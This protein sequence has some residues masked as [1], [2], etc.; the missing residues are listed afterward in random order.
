MPG[1]SPKMVGPIVHNQPGLPDALTL[2]GF[3][4]F[5]KV[6]IFE[7]DAKGNLTPTFF[8]RQKFGYACQPGQAPRHKYGQTKDEHL[9]YIKDKG[10]DIKNVNVN[11][12]LYSVVVT[13]EGKMIKYT[14]FESRWF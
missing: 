5:N 3:H 4:Q 14:Y 1:L 2:E 10:V 13:P 8:E 9:K 11:I 6:F 7:L 12:P